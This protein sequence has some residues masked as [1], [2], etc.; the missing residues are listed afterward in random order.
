MPIRSPRGRAAAYRA[1]WQWPLRSPARL[2]V[3]SVLVV[4]LAVGLSV[5]VGALG[6]GGDA[7]ATRVGATPTPVRPAPAAPSPTALPPVAELTP[8]SLPLSR[9][10]EAA[11]QVARRWSAAWLRPRAGVGTEE[12]L[13][14]MRPYTS[15]EYLGVLAAVDPANIPATRL[16]GEPR[17]VRVAPRSVQVEVPTDALTLLVLVVDT[18]DGWRVAGYERA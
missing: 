13:D 10:P 11:M 8:S 3:T 17:P 4:A 15:E 9:A 6:G 2:A 16:T 18:E 14:G 1:L 12:W 5:G 7:P